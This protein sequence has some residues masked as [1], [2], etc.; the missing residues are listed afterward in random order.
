LAAHLYDS[1][2]RG[3]PRKRRCYRTRK[4]YSEGAGAA[5]TGILVGGPLT[6]S[7]LPARFRP[8]EYFAFGHVCSKVNPGEII[9]V[10]ETKISESVPRNYFRILSFR[11]EN[12][13]SLFVRTARNPSGGRRHVFFGRR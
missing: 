8:G 13:K 2:G 1:N 11:D 7:E 10:D 5:N 6:E 4:H 3:W 12:C 9:S